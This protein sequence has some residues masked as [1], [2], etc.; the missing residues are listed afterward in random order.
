MATLTL[1]VVSALGTNATTLTF[2][3]GDASRILT[4]FQNRVT[5]NG[6]QADLV[7]WL[8]SKVQEDIGR[9]VVNSET[10]VTAPAPPVMS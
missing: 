8:A 5:A 3:S 7:T 9:M 1:T 10:V 4:A 2:S 6:T